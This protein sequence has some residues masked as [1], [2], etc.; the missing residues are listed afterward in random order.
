MKSSKVYRVGILGAGFIAS[1]HVRAIAAIKKTQ[2]DVVAICDQDFVKAKHLADK[3]SN[4]V[5][6]CSS[7]EEILVLCK[8]GKIDVVHNLLPVQFHYETT[9]TFMEEG[10]TVLSEKPLC[11]SPN[12]ASNLVQKKSIES[13]IA[14]SHNFCFSPVY[15]RLYKDVH[16]GK[17]GIIEQIEI[18][19]AK[20]L[21]S[22]DTGPYSSW[23]FSDPKNIAFEIAPHPIAFLLDLCGV[24]ESFKV[25]VENSIS[26]PNQILFPTDWDITAKVSST[27]IKIKVSLG[28]GFEEHEVRVRGRWGRCCADI[29]NRNYH[30]ELATGLSIDFDRAQRMIKRGGSILAQGIK[31]YRDIA[32]LGFQFRHHPV[33]PFEETIF[34]SISTFYQ[35]LDSKPD[36][37]HSLEYSH[38]V[39]H[40]CDKIATAFQEKNNQQ[41]SIPHSKISDPSQV[42]K[43]SALVI[44]GTG[45]IGKALV[46]HF[47]DLGVH[48]RVLSPS[49][50]QG[51]WGGDESNIEPI[52]GSI[53]NSELLNQSIKG[54]RHVYNL[55]SVAGATWLEREQQ[56]ARATQKLG[57][58]CLLHGV[59]RL[60][61]TS[62]IHAYYSGNPNTIITETTPLDRKIKNRGPYSR[63]K[64]TNESILIDMNKKNGLPV[65]ICR[66]G[67]VIGSG[68][69]PFHYGIGLW[70]GEGNCRF[71]GKGD[72]LLPFILVD[73]VAKGLRLAA[74]KQVSN[75]GIYLLTGKPCLTARDYIQQLVKYTDL[76]FDVK[77][78]PILNYYIENALLSTIKRIVKHP[79]KTPAPT[80]RDWLCN[81]HLSTYDSSWTMKQLNWQP[82]ANLDRFISLG[83]HRP[84]DEFIL[85]S[86]LAPKT[87]KIPRHSNLP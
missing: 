39:V 36:K 5:K 37:R 62:S 57:Q 18:I 8:N 47:R 3:I 11:I 21:T 63:I 53:V 45:F 86:S 60:V 56:E 67:I 14:V 79:D 17:L 20:P 46:R 85:G 9:K 13:T 28:H 31:H 41:F 73:D 84:A 23:L 52:A 27:L 25:R 43:E 83:I 64:Y 7:I 65:A 70:N 81:A 6:V 77:P 42:S 50:M 29:E 12:Q 55:V 1:R 4:S 66:P 32:L 61:Y 24:P 71:W 48:V 19:W 82:E 15:E 87:S 51:L 26:L 49:A 75:V 72:N 34:R 40:F 74:E 35:N 38:N 30:L 33:N 76:T 69:S 59:E 10:I 2:V 80:Y 44:G 16:S 54:T 68:G 78:R 58:L 22:L